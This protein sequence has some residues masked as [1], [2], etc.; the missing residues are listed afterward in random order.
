MDNSTRKQGA[1]ETICE[2]IRSLGARGPLLLMVEDIHWADQITLDLLA[3]VTTA[4]VDVPALLVITT[5]VEGLALERG[6]LASLHGC[7]LTTMELQPLR[8]EEALELAVDLAGSALDALETYVGRSEGNPLFLEQLVQNASETS[9]QD[10]PDTLHG[11]VLARVDRLPREDREAVQVASVL[12]QRFPLDALH[13]IL[14]STNYD[15]AGLLQHRIVRPE[16]PDYLFAHAL[17]R[18]GV[19]SSLLQARRRDLH[20]RAAVFFAERDAVLHAEHLDRASSPD[21]PRAYLAAAQDEAKQVRYENALRLAARALEIVPEADSFVLRLLQGELLRSLGSVPES[22]TAYRQALAVA[23]GETECCR[24]LIGVAEGLRLKEQHDELLRT[25]DEAEAAAEAQGLLAELSRTLQLRGS[26]HFI[27]GEIDACLRVNTASLQ[28][29]RDAG[30]P[31][32]EAQ[33]LGGL[34]EADFARGRMISA[35]KSYDECIGLSRE[36]G[37]L[38]VVAANLPMRGETL[39]YMNDLEAAMADCRAAIELA[40]KISQPRAEMVAAIVAAYIAELNDP[41]EGEKWTKL[42]LD[43]SRRL[44]ARLFESINLEHLGRFAEQMGEHV[45]AEKLVQEAIA[46]L[47]ES[48]SGMRFLAGRSFGALALITRDAK[49]QGSAL[50]EGEA[51]LHKGAPAHNQ[52]WFNR[53]AIEVCLKTAQWARV[54]RYAKALEDYTSAEPLPWSDFFIA[55]GRALAAFGL[56]RRDEESVQEMRRLRDEAK[57][58][59]LKNAL[60]AVEEALASS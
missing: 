21:A 34:G 30:S 29:A 25:L 31:E 59:G 20:S 24:A 57:R 13:H 26:V 43:I 55:R 9:A 32:L 7:P 50:D 35:H 44:G 47:R 3:G 19:Y 60:P 10:L 1:I 17:V 6:W 54:E 58:V 18:E 4:V 16:G 51:L 53:D 40:T 11:L 38:R 46:I 33:A 45:E 56:G 2:L 14:G 28:L 27:R 52:L 42:S 5:R 48:E 39:E 37:F 49:R 8:P 22:I 23:Q 12:G 41:I 36:H 15:C